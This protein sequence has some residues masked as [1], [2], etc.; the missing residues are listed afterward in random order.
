MCVSERERGERNF[1]EDVKKPSNKVFFS[2]K[3][4]QTRCKSDE[5]KCLN[6]CQNSIE[7]VIPLAYDCVLSKNNITLKNLQVYMQTN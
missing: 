6:K 1:I 4:D 5:M 2:R 7:P 3:V